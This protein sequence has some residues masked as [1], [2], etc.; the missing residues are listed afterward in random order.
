MEDN[1]DQEGNICIPRE[2]SS[3]NQHLSLALQAIFH[4][5]PA[6]V[7]QKRILQQNRLP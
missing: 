7:I 4:L 3:K 2:L 6:T 1:A 5:E